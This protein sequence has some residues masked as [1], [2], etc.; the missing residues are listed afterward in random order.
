MRR[1][2]RLACAIF[3]AARLL[4]AADDPLLTAERQ[5]EV[6][7]YREAITT[8]RAALSQSP[9]DARLHFWLARSHFELRELDNAVSSAERAVQLAPQNS[10]YH[11]WLGRA[12]GDKADRERSFSLAR[13]TKREFEE[14]VRLNPANIP[15]RRALAEYYADAPWIV[16]GGKDKAREQ[17]AAIE[18]LDPVEAHLARADYWRSENK[19]DQAEAE[20]RHVLELKPSRVDPY[21]EVADFFR[22]RNARAQMEAAVAAAARVAP[23]DP[24][25]SYYRGVLHVMTRDDL[26][27]A[28]ELLLSYLSAVPE[29][30]DYPSHASA[31]AWLGRVYELQGKREQAAE[32]FR[33]ALRLDPRHRGALDGLKRVE[34]RR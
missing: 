30:T 15:A 8:L 34:P 2:L 25:L 4:A 19:P 9:Q 33:A 21:L 22:N 3:L 10:D 32:Q 28:E 5:F 23:A 26:P 24:R 20:Y 11:Y 29:R 1:G 27:K 7:K 12:Y 17:I 13:K 14:A 18:N 31:H 16:G 6:G